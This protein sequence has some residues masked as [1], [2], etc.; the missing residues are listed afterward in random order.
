[1]AAQWHA[2]NL[3]G[4]ATDEDPGRSTVSDD[5]GQ[6]TFA[7]RPS[8]SP[9]RALGV[10]DDYVVA[11]SQPVVLAAPGSRE[12]VELKMRRAGVVYGTV[13]RNG[14]PFQGG[15][16]GRAVGESA[17]PYYTHTE[18]GGTYEMKR[19]PPGELEIG[20]F[21][22]VITEPLCLAT[23]QV[24]AGQRLQ[25][26]FAWEVTTGKIS[27]KVTTASGGPLA[28]VQVRATVDGASRDENTCHTNADGSYVLEVEVGKLYTIQ[29][30]SGV[31]KAEREE[32]VVGASDV[33]FVLASRGHLRLR[34]LDAASRE[35]V[36]ISGPG[37]W[38]LAW[39]NSDTEAFSELRQT[40][41]AGG[42]VDL[43]LPLGAVDVVVSM[44]A[45]G[46]APQHAWGLTVVDQTAP[47]PIELLL[48]RGVEVRVE[49]VGPSSPADDL[50]GHLLFLLHDSQRELVR[51]PFANQGGP[52]NMRING[53]NMWIG[54]P[55]L[56]HQLLSAEDDGIAVLKGLVPGDYRLLAYPDDFVFTPATV[57]IGEGGGTVRLQWRRR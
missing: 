55:G 35:P 52:S 54:E 18:S 8:S 22:T 33:D 28:D 41:D 47:E 9:L 27:G 16:C 48:K 37:W 11:Q 14:K 5:Q 36:R 19:L 42:L 13:R 51:G 2:Q 49:L 57:T 10:L 3:T 29:V 12:I 4:S 44:L 53:I 26:D 40:P 15:L 23:V 30:R 20:F 39:R 32:V 24:L 31:V 1:M 21:A 56:M 45:A 34:L 46:Y 43:E 38:G 6:F 17:W 7:V 50:G 25:H